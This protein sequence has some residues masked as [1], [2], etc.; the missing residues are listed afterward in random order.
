MGKYIF[1]TNFYNLIK[2]AL[3]VNILIYELLYST[4]YRNVEGERRVCSDFS[5][6]LETLLQDVNRFHP[7]TA[8]IVILFK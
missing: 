3:I 6:Q 2:K 1:Y 7:A 4:N 8:H 5:S